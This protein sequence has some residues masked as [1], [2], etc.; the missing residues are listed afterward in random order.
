MTIL[1]LILDIV[2]STILD[3]FGA[4]ILV[5]FWSWFIAIGE[6]K[7]W[8]AF[9]AI[10]IFDLLTVP[11][12]TFLAN[13]ENKDIEEIVALSFKRVFNRFMMY[14]VLLSVGGLIYHIFIK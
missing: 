14:F 10:Y 7:F 1:L 5:S 8:Q 6:L 9:G 2:L 13:E 11:I 3:F 4:L 12:L